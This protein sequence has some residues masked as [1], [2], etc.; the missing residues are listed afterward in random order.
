[1][2]RTHTLTSQCSGPESD[3]LCRATRKV[4]FTR[5]GKGQSI[6]LFVAVAGGRESNAPRFYGGA[7]ATYLALVHSSPSFAQNCSRSASL[8]NTALRIVSILRILTI[9]TVG[10][11][12]RHGGGVRIACFKRKFVVLLVRKCHHQ[13]V[14]AHAAR[15]QNLRSQPSE[16]GGVGGPLPSVAVNTPVIRRMAH[17]LRGCRTVEAWYVFCTLPLVFRFCEAPRHTTAAA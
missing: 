12:R 7:A 8:C 6:D 3:A 11:S 15:Q 16:V 13:H 9:R 2:E 14:L 1:M 4:A 5:A 17:A 10:R